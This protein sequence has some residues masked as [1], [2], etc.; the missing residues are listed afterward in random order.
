MIATG[1]LG[2]RADVIVDVVMT[3]SGFLP[4]LM[5][6]TFYLAAKGKYRLHRQM[7]MGLLLVVTVLVVALE[8]VVRSGDLQAAKALSSYHDSVIL[9]VVFIVHLFF[10]LTTF[11]GWLWLVIKSAKIYPHQFGTFNH[12]KWGKLLFVDVI[13]TVITGWL[14]YLMVF[15]W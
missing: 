11:V 15:A 1:F 13:M 10:A 4:A 8:V 3:V 7:Q 12:K 9:R 14:I 6:Y 2:T 5:M